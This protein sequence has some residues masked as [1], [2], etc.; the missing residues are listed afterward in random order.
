MLGYGALVV[1]YRAMAE[2]RAAAGAE[3]TAAYLAQEQ[4]AWIEGQQASYLHAHGT[5]SWRGGE[6]AAPERNGTQFDISSSVSQHSE[7]AALAVVETHV[8]WQIRGRQREETYR[9]LVAYHE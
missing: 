3:I 5:I 6:S 4:V 1:A 2:S 8:R 9:K 7:T